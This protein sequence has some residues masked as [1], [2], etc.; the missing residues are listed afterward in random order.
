[1]STGAARRRALLA[2]GAALLGCTA[3]PA[4]ALLPPAVGTPA[5]RPRPAAPKPGQPIVLDWEDLL[6]ENK[7]GELAL[8]PPPPIHDYL[9]GE[10][11]PAAR[12]TGDFSVNPKLDGKLV[13]LPGFLVP[14]ELDQTG[15]IAEMFLVPYYGACIHV[16]PPP[17]NQIVYVAT[18]KAFSMESLY[19]AYWVT[20]RL[21]VGKRSTRIASAAY[22]IDATVIEEYR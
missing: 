20:G 1:M 3:W 15:R 7:R 18:R 21:K 16:P 5:P 9:S 11:G 10:R 6:P 13:R 22:S 4:G 17:P 12:Q 8:L 14:L 2:F 19:S